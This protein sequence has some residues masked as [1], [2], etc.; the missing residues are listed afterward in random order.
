[1][2][3]RNNAYNI[4]FLRRKLFT[5]RVCQ[6]ERSQYSGLCMVGMGHVHV[7]EKA[8][9]CVRI[10]LTLGLDGAVG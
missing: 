9:V 1:M 6:L 7:C 4:G 3:F 8:D 10:I 2:C 5:G